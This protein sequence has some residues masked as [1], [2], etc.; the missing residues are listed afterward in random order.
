MDPA[1]LIV[2]ALVS[3]ILAGVTRSAQHAVYEGYL[4]L[5]SA[6]LCGY[7]ARSGGSL[8]QAIKALEVEPTL[9]DRQTALARQLQFVGADQDPQLQK[10]A[11]ELIS[12]VEDPMQ[13]LVSPIEQ[14]HHHA[15]VRAVARIMD[16]H[17]NT[18]L[19]LRERLRLDDTDLLTA[20]DGR[21]SNVPRE[22]SDE[23]ARL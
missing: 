3:G 6:I 9:P 17:I 18:V 12:L 1:S 22:V 16:R 5:R 13:R 7:G 20:S 19:N 21:S 14:A 2:A 8:E 10:L 11:N 23:V 4:D 15:G